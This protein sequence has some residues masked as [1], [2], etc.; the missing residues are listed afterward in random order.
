[1]RVVFGEF[2]AKLRE[3]QGQNS[4]GVCA[5]MCMRVCVSRSLRCGTKSSDH[6]EQ[7]RKAPSVWSRETSNIG[8]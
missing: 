3:S 1:M 6:E 4:V 8:M 7:M 2:V 5:H